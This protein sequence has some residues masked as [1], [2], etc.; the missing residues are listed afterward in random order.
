MGVDPA[1][2]IRKAV[3]ER[4]GER[5]Y[6]IAWPSKTEVLDAAVAVAVDRESRAR[7]VRDEALGTLEAQVEDLKH[8]LRNKRED[9]TRVKVA[10]QPL[11]PNEPEHAR[12]GWLAELTAERISDVL[13]ML[14]DH[15][16]DTRPQIR[17]ALAGDT[18]EATDG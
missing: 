2:E 16:A 7:E 4:I 8:E 1:V 9:Y 6:A 5:F 12:A 17:D 10:L 13:A 11:F 3:I 18:P 15:G 14:D